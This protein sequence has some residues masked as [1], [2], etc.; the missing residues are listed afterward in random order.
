[1]QVLNLE[2]NAEVVV[3]GEEYYRKQWSEGMMDATVPSDQITRTSH[4]PMHKLLL[5]HP[6]SNYQS[7]MPTGNME[8]SRPAFRN[9]VHAYP[10]A[11]HPV[12]VRSRA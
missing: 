7:L 12:F 9:N 10:G 1:M 6:R 5:V 4:V 8:H 3:N 11:L 2:Q